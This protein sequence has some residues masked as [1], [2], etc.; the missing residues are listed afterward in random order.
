M[1]GKG[2]GEGGGEGVE[3]VG[4]GFEGAKEFDVGALEGEELEE[5]EEEPPV[6]GDGGAAVRGGEEDAAVREGDRSVEARVGGV[7]GLV[8][9]L[10]EYEI[11]L[12]E[13]DE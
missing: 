11:S 7:G 13:L 5:P 8:E 10:G 6:G 3:D 4:G 2:V 12:L 1:L 9:C